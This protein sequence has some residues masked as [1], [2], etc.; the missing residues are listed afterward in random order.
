MPNKTIYVSDDDM[1]LYRRAQELAGGN[2]S[3]AIVTAL[4]HYVEME[5]GRRQGFDEITVFVGTGPGRKVRFAGVLLVEWGQSS[6]KKTEVYHVY[7]TAKGKFAVHTKLTGVWDMEG[8]WRGALGI[9]PLTWHTAEDEA[10]LE[11][12]ETLEELRELVPPQLFDMVKAVA[13]QPAV[14]DLDI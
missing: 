5:E 11:V 13:K 14:E 6:A 2:L 8:G 3:A 12:A 4:R 7:R 9:G 10:T 1:P